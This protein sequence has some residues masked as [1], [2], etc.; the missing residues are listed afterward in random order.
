MKT[1]FLSTLAVLM[2]SCTV[3]AQQG[4]VM[5]APSEK[6][7]QRF[8]KNETFEFRLPNHI[9]AN[10]VAESAAY[11][12]VYFDVEFDEETH[13]VRLKMKSMEE[14]S[15]HVMVR[16]FVSLELSKIKVDGQTIYWEDYYQKY[17]K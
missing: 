7:L 9:T 14:R 5:E 3:F 1:F 17:I 10:Q 6:S 2:M 15:K 8:I 12:T 11:Y 16:F 4:T 13:L